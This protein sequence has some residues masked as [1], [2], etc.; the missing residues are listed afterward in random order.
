[1]KGKKDK[2]W[3][4]DELI[5]ILAVEDTQRRADQ[6]RITKARQKVLR[7]TPA[8]IQPVDNNFEVDQEYSKRILEGL[9][10]TYSSG[11]SSYPIFGS[12]MVFV[13]SNNNNE[14]NNTEYGTISKWW[15]MASATIN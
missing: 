3:S 5:R 4:E 7:D 9:M 10:V 12:L 1:M 2:D 6:L 8:I 11:P 13:L 14:T 15:I